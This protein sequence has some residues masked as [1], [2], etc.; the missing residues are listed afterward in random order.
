MIPKAY[1]SHST[2]ERL[3][4]QVP[5]KKR[6]ANFFSNVQSVFSHFNDV[7]EIVVNELTGSV[8]LIASKINIDTIK[9]YA[10]TNQLF[11]IQEKESSPAFI[12]ILPKP[13]TKVLT[14]PIGQINK[15]IERKTSESLDLAG[16]FFLSLM[17][18]GMVQALRGKATL[19]GWHTALWYS[20]GI[21]SSVLK[22]KNNT[23]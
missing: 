19:P 18:I 12:S 8:L 5:E 16:M 15:A 21:Y 10:K 23:S 1:I 13:L 3:R 7:D 6:N 4:I 20:F 9:N 17:S 14:V 22:Q 2:N 11:D